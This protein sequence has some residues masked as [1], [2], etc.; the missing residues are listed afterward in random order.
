MYSPRVADSGEQWNFLCFCGVYPWNRETEKKWYMCIKN[1]LSMENKS[2]KARAFPLVHFVD[3]TKGLRW[4]VCMV[5]HNHE[6][7]LELLLALRV[8]WVM[9]KDTWKCSS[10][11]QRSLHLIN[12]SCPMGCLCFY[13]DSDCFLWGLLLIVFRFH[14]FALNFNL[15]LI[16]HHC[17]SVT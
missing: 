14:A 11:F 17:A 12:Q 16:F 2:G 13:L 15:K 7:V 1:N 4:C 3:L 9:E 8:N 6:Y 5:N 10:E